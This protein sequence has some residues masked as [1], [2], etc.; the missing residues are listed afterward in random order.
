MVKDIHTCQPV[1]PNHMYCIAN[2]Q[3][4]NWIKSTRRIGSLLPVASKHFPITLYLKRSM[5]DFKV[6]FALIFNQVAKTS[7][8]INR[9]SGMHHT[10]IRGNHALT[11]STK[12][13]LVAKE[14]RRGL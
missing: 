3:L 10:L 11:S 12:L 2:I 9:L 1:Y 13:C 8:G 4:V 6:S 5:I 14:L 7:V